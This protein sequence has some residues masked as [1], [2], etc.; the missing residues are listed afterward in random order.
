MPHVE[1]SAEDQKDFQQI[2][3]CIVSNSMRVIRAGFN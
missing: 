1:F 3:T 2:I